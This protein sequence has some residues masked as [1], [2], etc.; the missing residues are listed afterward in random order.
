[1]DLSVIV[2]NAIKKIMDEAQNQGVDK[3]EVVKLIE[4]CL[5]K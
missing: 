2:D 1:M 5:D 3:A 4:K